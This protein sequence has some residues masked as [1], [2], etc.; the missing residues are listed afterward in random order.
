MW[1]VVEREVDEGTK[2][3]RQWAEDDEALR[4]ALQNN[5]SGKADMAQAAAMKQKSRGQ[6]GCCR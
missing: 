6:G 1:V 4:A 3:G 5:D 2:Q